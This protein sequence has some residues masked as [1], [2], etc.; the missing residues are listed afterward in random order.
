M[1]TI[2]LNFVIAHQEYFIGVA[3][4]VAIAHIPQIVCYGFHLAMKVPWLRSAVVS[5][6]KQAKAI[7]D[8][9]AQE[10]DKDID[11][12]AAAPAAPPKAAA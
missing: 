11:E 3:S 12:E 4:G 10:L 9:I 2:A 1:G 7:V 6:P 5:N 8:A